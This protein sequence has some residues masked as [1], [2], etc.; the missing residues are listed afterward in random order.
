M[1]SLA[2]RRLA[3]TYRPNLSLY[4]QQRTFATS[5]PLCSDANNQTDQIRTVTL[6]P[7]NK[8]KTLCEYK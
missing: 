1:S 2:L 5:L 4:K 8:R 6:I 3:L 7:G